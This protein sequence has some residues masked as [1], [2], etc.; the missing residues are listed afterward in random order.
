MTVREN[1]ERQETVELGANRLAGTDPD[2]IVAAARAMLG[3]EGWESPYG[4]GH[5]AERILDVLLGET[6]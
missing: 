3:A 2:D 5:T 1:T 4:D 6:A